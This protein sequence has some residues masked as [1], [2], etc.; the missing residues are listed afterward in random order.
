MQW[1]IADA[2]NPI[3][4]QDEDYYEGEY[5]EG[6]K[7]GNGKMVYKK[8]NIVYEGQWMKNTYNGEGKMWWYP[9][10]EDLENNDDT[11]AQTYTGR[12]IDNKHQGQGVYYWPDKKQTFRGKRQFPSRF[13]FC[14]KTLKFHLKK[15]F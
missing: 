8:R 10:H 12:W 13:I 2:K 6:Y 4:W 1:R 11:H 5:H 14:S 15:I 3:N 7:H 9:S